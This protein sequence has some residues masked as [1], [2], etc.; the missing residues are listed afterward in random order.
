MNNDLIQLADVFA[1]LYYSHSK[2]II[3][4]ARRILTKMVIQFFIINPNIK[5][6]KKLF[7]WEKIHKPPFH[8]PIKR[9]EKTE[10]KFF[11][12]NYLNTELAL[13]GIFSGNF[14]KRESKFAET[15]LL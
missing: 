9:N 4:H 1:N 3:K 12:E 8:I 2:R 11:L 10:T 15:N 5:K 6:L 14:F 7:P 13:N